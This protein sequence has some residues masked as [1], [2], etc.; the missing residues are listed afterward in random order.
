MV[1]YTTV[2]PLPTYVGGLLSVALARGLLRVGVT[3]RFALW[4]PD[5]PRSSLEINLELQRGDPGD[6]FQ[7]I[8]STLISMK[9]R[10]IFLTSLLLLSACGS[11]T[12]VVTPTPTPTS[13]ER[14]V[15]TTCELPDVNAA[16][17]RIIPPSKYIPT[18]W[19]P[20]AGTDLYEA[21]NAGGI[22]CTYGDQDA[23]VG[24]TILWASNS[25]NVWDLRKQS[26]I[27]AGE[28]LIDLPGIEESEAFILQHGTSAD[29]M[30]V[31]R[32]NLL[33]RGVWIQVGASF[34]QN[35]DEALPIIK[36]SIA[37]IDQ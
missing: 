6:S 22:A 20:A 21:I 33:I 24:G 31:W 13:A 3:H 11:S 32:V 12:P 17:A 35:L 29:G 14:K 28:T 2:S 23:E 37:A 7:I 4:S 34:L 30:H 15:P 16:F 8:F 27:D 26:W 18:E 9:L 36:A 5:F 1:S 25:E 19:K 10:L